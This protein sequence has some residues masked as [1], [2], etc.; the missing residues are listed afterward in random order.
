MQKRNFY[1][2]GWEVE[3]EPVNEG[4]EITAITPEKCSYWFGGDRTYPTYRAALW[5]VVRHLVVDFWR[6]YVIVNSI[7]WIRYSWRKRRA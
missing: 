4:F 3:I 2:I 1:L 6:V 7:D 5:A